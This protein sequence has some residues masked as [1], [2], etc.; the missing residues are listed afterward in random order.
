MLFVLQISVVFVKLIGPLLDTD[1]KKSKKVEPSV[2]DF[3]SGIPKKA[4]EKVKS[5]VTYASFGENGTTASV[6]SYS[7]IIQM[8]RFLGMSTSGFFSVDQFDV[9]KPN[10]IKLR[11]HELEEK[12]KYHD[13]LNWGSF[14][15]EMSENMIQISRSNAQWEME[16]VHDRWPRLTSE[17]SGGLRIIINNFVSKGTVFQEAIH[18]T[19]E[20]PESIISGKKRWIIDLSDYRIR[21]LNFKSSDD[22][23]P[24]Q[25]DPYESYVTSNELGLILI[26]KKFSDQF[27]K[28]AVE[29]PHAVCL[30]TSISI[31]GKVQKLETMDGYTSSHLY[32]IKVQD[33]EGFAVKPKEP[34]T[35]TQ[36]FRLQLITKKKA[37]IGLKEIGIPDS[38]FYHYMDEILQLQP[39]FAKLTFAQHQQHLDFMIRRN[40]EHIL[41][42]CS[43]PIPGRG[44][45]LTCGDMS[46][47]RLVISASL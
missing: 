9:A 22:S 7:A 36:A 10:Y 15:S 29:N 13:G 19:K 8:T 16:F 40:L 12:C 6:N 18:E 37:W 31:N 42:V 21:E 5:P 26:Q 34:V 46:G 28:D 14:W 4:N 17:T 20:E 44:I 45:A 38:E 25:D 2:E 33:P 41:S 24:S 27:E 32:Q 35:I 1:D 43:I 11:A 39:S 47:H 23:G 3:S 30:I